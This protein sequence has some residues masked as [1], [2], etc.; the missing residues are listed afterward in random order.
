MPFGINPI[1]AVSAVAGTSLAGRRPHGKIRLPDHGLVDRT[2]TFLA[3][4][5]F[6]LG[7]E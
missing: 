1:M 2:M 3:F 7:T 4:L 6:A 5:H